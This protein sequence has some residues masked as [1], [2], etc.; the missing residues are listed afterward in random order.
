[1]RHIHIR[2]VGVAN[3]RARFG[4][5]QNQLRIWDRTQKQHQRALVPASHRNGREREN[6]TAPIC[7]ARHLNRVR[8]GLIPFRF[9][10]YNN[11]AFVVMPRRHFYAPTQ[12]FSARHGGA[13]EG[14][15]QASEERGGSTPYSGGF[16]ASFGCVTARAHR[17]GDRVERGD[18]EGDPL[19]LPARRH[20]LLGWTTRTRREAA[21][22]VDAKAGRAASGAPRGGGRARRG[23]RGGRVPARLSGAGRAQGRRLH[24][25]PPACPF[26]MAQARASSFPSAQGSRGGSLF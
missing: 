24:R 5:A 22:L 15:A 3:N 19:P 20:R 4:L 26:G 12:G 25:L 21:H 17:G 14:V 7:A 8:H 6:V 23:H 2:L 16:D 9:Q 1:M 10:T 18:G 11:S 13:I